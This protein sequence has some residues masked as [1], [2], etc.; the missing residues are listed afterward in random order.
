MKAHPKAWPIKAIRKAVEEKYTKKGWTQQFADEWPSLRTALA[1]L[2]KKLGP[3]YS[4]VSCLAVAGSRVVFHVEVASAQGPQPAALKVCRPLP[5]P[6]KLVV[7]EV[8]N[9]A[10]IFHPNLVRINWSDSVRV[11]DKNLDLPV[12]IEE[13]IP[14][15]LHIGDWLDS[16]LAQA[17]GEQHLL[18]TMRRF[19]ALLAD[20][21][22]G[23]KE[24]HS[25]KI[26][27]CDVKPENI[28]VK[29]GAAKIV[30]FGYS[31]RILPQTSSTD[32]S[33]A[34][35]FG[36]TW[37]YAS[38]IL[39][40][41]VHSMES[42]DATIAVDLPDVPFQHLDMYGLG[43]T[44]EECV[45]R[46]RKRRGELEEQRRKL[47]QVAKSTHGAECIYHEAFLDLIAA[48]LKGIEALN[49]E[50]DKRG[51]LRHAKSNVVKAIMYANEP[52]TWDQVRADLDRAWMDDASAMIPE[53]NRSSGQILRVGPVDVPFTARVR[54]LVNH[55]RLSRLA[56]V[57]QLGLVAFVYPGARHTRLEHSLGA[58]AAA[59]RYLE[60]LWRQKDDPF[61]RAVGTLDDLM[62]ISLAVLL[63]DIGQYPHCHDFE[64][65]LPDLPSHS[66]KTRELYRDRSTNGES[67]HDV[68]AQEWGDAVADRVEGF[69]EPAG[70]SELVLR[71]LRGVMSG[72]VD[73]DKLDYVQRDSHALGVGYG[74][75][76]EADRLI[77]ALRIVMDGG[78]LRLG[79]ASKGIFPA[80]SLIIA[81][82]QMFERVYWHKTVRSFKTMLSTALR[83][84]TDRKDLRDAISQLAVPGVDDTSTADVPPEALHLPLSDLTTLLRIRASFKDKRAE[85]LLDQVIARRPYKRIADLDW[86]TLSNSGI[87]SDL[88]KALDTL[89]QALYPLHTG[90]LDEA[91]WKGTYGFCER[92]RSAF[93][94]RLYDD[95]ILKGPGN[96]THA[97]RSVAVLV[98]IPNPQKFGQSRILVS[99]SMDAHP[100]EIE[101]GFGL[102]TDNQAWIRCTMPRVYLHPAFTLA[103]GHEEDLLNAFAKT[104]LKGARK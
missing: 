13:Y 58:Y 65:A 14:G 4:Y 19:H 60:A 47:Q 63:H 97:A 29:D 49:D 95:G 66:R 25:N 23:F 104:A 50:A 93:Q 17:G 51:A 92:V 35:E 18:D 10:G 103:A 64:D 81:R 83:I 54:R 20:A 102:T 96:A 48:R 34:H 32:N 24:L 27:H 2:E 90:G 28:L 46:I 71:G 56:Q 79:I 16:A 86:T 7:A 8:E 76:V 91:H 42:P 87:R 68:V 94:K 6:V 59:C 37:K 22:R 77:R 44:I 26:L 31:K 98:D 89:T 70:S 40:K 15:G 84:E 61:L 67:L 72:P 53:W 33:A 75:H 1:Q 73:A 57:S 74:A 30:D 78:D 39:R 52:F 9:V 38:P 85:Y 99:D 100:K 41:H 80:Q 12:T 21:A 88:R 82:Q 69:L 43:R 3:T 45:V 5:Q 55:A 36:F 101:L 11:P 62:A